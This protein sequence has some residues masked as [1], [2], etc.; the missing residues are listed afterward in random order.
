MERNRSQTEL[1]LIEAIEALI[2]EKGFENLGV[3]AVSE[4]AGVDKTL[5]YRYF[6]SLD[7]LIYECLKKQD[8]WTNVPIEIPESADMKGYVKDLFKRQ[9]SELRNNAILKR[10]LR[11]ELSND[12]AFITELR[13]QRETNGLKR[14]EMISETTKIPVEDVA[15]L[16][17]IITGGVCYL[18]MAGETCQYFNGIDITSDN[19]WE[20]LIKGINRMIDLIYNENGI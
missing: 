8:F 18:V 11:W 6:G 20:E 2:I 14:I 17:S 10:L 4:K 1:R 15:A 19:G 9:I 3:R 16:S 12:N 5:I 7:G 13:N